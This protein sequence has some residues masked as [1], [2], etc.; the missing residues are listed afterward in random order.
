MSAN[1]IIDF[2]SANGGSNLVF[3]SL[4]LPLGTAITKPDVFIVKP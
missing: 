2:T 4:S 1:S 3:R